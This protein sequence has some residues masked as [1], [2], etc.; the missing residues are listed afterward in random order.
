MKQ[1]ILNEFKDG[2]KYRPP[3][4][5]LD[6]SGKDW[7]DISATS[8]QDISPAMDIIK[9]IPLT[10]NIKHVCTNKETN[11]SRVGGIYHVAFPRWHFLVGF[12]EANQVIICRCWRPTAP[13]WPEETSRCLNHSRIIALLGNFKRW[14]EPTINLDSTVIWKSLLVLQYSSRNEMNGLKWET[15]DRTLPVCLQVDL[16]KWLLSR[17]EPL[18][19][20]TVW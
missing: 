1:S 14:Q 3:L 5:L 12:C 6:T 4:G 20:D 10:P 9:E 2:F 19:W 16:R 18:F 17:T 7:Y 11:T 13:K 15:T 8:I